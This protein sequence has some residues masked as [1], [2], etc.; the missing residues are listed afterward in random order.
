[1]DAI[2]HKILW[3]DSM[4]TSL[5]L[6]S[7]QHKL[8]RSLTPAQRAHIE[9]LVDARVAK[10]LGQTPTTSGEEGNATEEVETIKTVDLK[11]VGFDEAAKIKVIKEVRAIAGLGLKEAK[12]VVEKVPI[13]IQKGLAPEKAQEIKEVIEKAGGKVEIV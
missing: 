13:V 10:R 12:E 1:M 6:A 5:L 2:F 11:L 8:D 4:E 7:M 3:L 9:R